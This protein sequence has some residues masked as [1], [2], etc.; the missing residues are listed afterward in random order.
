MI[1]YVLEGATYLIG[2][3]ERHHVEGGD[4]ST[5]RVLRALV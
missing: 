1:S 5:D 3:K 4:G 2:A